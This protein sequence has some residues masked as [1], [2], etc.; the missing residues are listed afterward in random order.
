VTSDVSTG[1]APPEPE[2]TELGQL[3]DEL[4]SFVQSYVVM[5]AAQAD[6]VALWTAHTHALDA[7]ETTPFLA[8]TSPEKRCGKTRLL[9]VLELVVA[10]P[11]RAV[12]PSE[13]VLYRKIE[14]SQPTLLLDE[15]DAIFNLGN[16]NTEPLRALLNA[17]NRRGTFVPRCVGPTQ[18][19]SDFAIF[20]SKALAGIGQLPDTVADRTIVVRLTRKRPGESARRFRRREAL[21]LAEP[22]AS[23]LESWAQRAVPELEAARPEIPEALDDRAEEG[24]EPLLAIADLA[25]GAWPE[26]AR[27]A[28]LELSTG[29]SREDDSIGV[30]LLA[31]IHAVFQ[32]REVDRLSTAELLE[33]LAADEE[34]PWADWR[35]GP[36]GPRPLARMLA[37]FKIKSRTIR[38][39]EGTAKGYLREQFEDDW[40]R[41]LRPE[42]VT[43]SQGASLSEK[44]AILYPSQTSLVTD[45]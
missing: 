30:R 17:G 44:Q 24:W 11:W 32:A 31:D 3:L 13:A 27:R 7:F 16:G 42:S 19:I 1:Y 20:C 41:Y 23:S 34:S 5:S 35:G 45:A 33:A 8:V 26:H 6:A 18:Q 14:S 4:L 43:P 2:L 40:A 12:M 22:L 28:A 29:D 25:G 38:L 9:D 21:E 15:T 36:I 10:R 39:A 37:R